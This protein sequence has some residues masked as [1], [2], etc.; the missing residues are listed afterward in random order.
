MNITVF[1][2]S[3]YF[4]AARKAVAD[5]IFPEGAD[6]RNK[7]ER[8]ANID[9]LTGLANR[10]AFDLAAPTAAADTQ[11][12]VILFD[13]NNFGKVNKVLGHKA[14]DDLLR[15]MAHVIHL[16]AS[17]YGL[18]ERCFRLGGDEFVILAPLSVAGLLRD[19]VEKMYDPFLLDDGTAVSIS[20]T[21]GATLEDADITLQARKNARKTTK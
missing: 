19:T 3:G 14:G 17:R 1:P 6:L 13:A 20:G 21:M 4:T 7:A 12:C 16:A 9:V 8:A 15:N 5:I 11:V 2:Q 10:R 18:G